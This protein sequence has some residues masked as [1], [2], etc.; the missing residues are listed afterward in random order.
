MTAKEHHLSYQHKGRFFTWGN[1]EKADHLLICLHG[2]GQLASYF[3]RKFHNLPENIFVVCPEG[4]HRFYQ[5]GTAGRVGASWMTKEDRLVDIANYIAFLDQ[6]YATQ[7]A[8]N[9]FKKKT[10]LGFSQGGATASRWIAQ[11]DGQFDTFL[12]WAAVFP[13]DMDISAQSKFSAQRNIF[14]IGTQDEYTSIEK[15]ACYHKSLNTAEMQFEFV[16]FDGNHQ[17]DVALLTRLIV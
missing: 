1:P 16:K 3:I 9:L 7:L 11:G 14:V 2:Y 17:V 13:P 10:L 6:L 15:A 5:A 12:L 8:N 4:P